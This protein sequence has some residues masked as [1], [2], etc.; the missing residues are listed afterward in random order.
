MLL[1]SLKEAKVTCETRAQS[2]T[3]RYLRVTSREMKVLGLSVGLGNEDG[4][5]YN[6]GMSKV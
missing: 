1:L 6:V 2:A 3:K 5:R 4:G